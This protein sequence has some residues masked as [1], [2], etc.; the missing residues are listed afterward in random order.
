MAEI[1]PLPLANAKVQEG[2]SRCRCGIDLGWKDLC[3]GD[4]GPRFEE[5]PEGGSVIGPWP[6]RPDEVWS[7]RA[8]FIL[9]HSRVVIVYLLQDH[10]H[11]STTTFFSRA[12]SVVRF[13]PRHQSHTSFLVAAGANSGPAMVSNCLKIGIGSVSHIF[14]A[15]IRSSHLPSDLC[16]TCLTLGDKLPP[17]RSRVCNSKTD[18]AAQ[19]GSPWTKM[20][21]QGT[22]AVHR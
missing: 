2:F 10:E 20:P 9:H 7:M 12:L 4:S 6:I 11:A 15:L 21:H 17:K 22:R 8:N 1:L 5:P 14:Y 19:D 13:G 16:K 3:H 18:S